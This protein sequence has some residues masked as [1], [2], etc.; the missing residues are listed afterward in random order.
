MT[1]TFEELDGKYEV[2]SRPDIEG[3]SYTVDGDGETEIQNGR[4][5]R[6]D[7]NGL[8]WESAFS[9][10]GPDKVLMESTVDPSHSK[11]ARGGRTY[12]RD[13][14]GHPTT[15]VLTFRTVLDVSR[16][17]GRLVLAGV[18]AHGEERTR[19]TLTKIS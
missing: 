5:F 1:I 19:L 8:I 15:S 13:A 16:A 6:K 4:T 9:I 18:I 17:G 14:Q 11:A 3:A 10:V 12:L 2:R 7:K